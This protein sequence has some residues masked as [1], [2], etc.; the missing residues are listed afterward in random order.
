MRTGSVWINTYHILRPDV[1]FG[2]YK[3]SGYGRENCY[4]ALMAYSEVKH[5]CQ[6]LTPDADDKLVNLLI[7]LNNA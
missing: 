3:E 6:D 5:V 7:G 2:G 4:H 1:P